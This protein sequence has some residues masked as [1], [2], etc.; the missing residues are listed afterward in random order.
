MLRKTLALGALLAAGI[1]LAGCDE[2]ARIASQNLSTAAD[3]FQVLRRITVLNTRSGQPSLLIEGACSQ[4]GDRIVRIIC[5]MPDGSYRKT[6]V[7]A[8]ETDTVLSEQLGSTATS[9]TRYVV[10]INPAEIIP[11]FKVR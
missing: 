3:N 5:K 11:I 8:A 10:T 1:S 9:G 4:E 6:I 7:S 2:E